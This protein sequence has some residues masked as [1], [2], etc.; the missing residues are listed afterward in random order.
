MIHNTHTHPSRGMHPPYYSMGLRLTLIAACVS[1]AAVFVG[2]SSSSITVATVSRCCDRQDTAHTRQASS[3][4]TPS[5]TNTSP[6]ATTMAA[7]RVVRFAEMVEAKQ[8][9]SLSLL[10]ILSINK[11]IESWDISLKPCFPVIAGVCMLVLQLLTLLYTPPKK[12]AE[13]GKKSKKKMTR[14]EVKNQNKMMLIW[15][16]MAVTVVGI[17]R[18]L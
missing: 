11:K 13:K 17:F 10:S 12:P 4:T 16:V 5:T 18:K 8:E 3:T 2:G 7:T 14:E 6:T 15:V 1:A 9:R